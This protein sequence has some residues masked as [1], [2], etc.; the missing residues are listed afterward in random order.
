MFE[1]RLPKISE[2]HTMMFPIL[3]PTFFCTNLQNKAQKLKSNDPD[4]HKVRKINIILFH[5]PLNSLRF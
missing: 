3:A 4:I 1:L 2:N 5:K